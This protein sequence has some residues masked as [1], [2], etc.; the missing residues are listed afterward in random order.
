[1]AVMGSEDSLDF[2]YLMGCAIA[3]HVIGER[4]NL[5]LWE[6]WFIRP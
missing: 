3:A 1:M 2:F 6:G 4:Y 5:C